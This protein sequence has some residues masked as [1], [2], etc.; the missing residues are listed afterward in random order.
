[1]LILQKPM[2]PKL[3]IIKFN[4]IPNY[5][6]LLVRQLWDRDQWVIPP[7]VAGPARPVSLIHHIQLLLLLHWLRFHPK[8]W[9]NRSGAWQQM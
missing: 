4:H 2:V 9:Q 8:M 1:M 3:L 6:R 7:V 5:A